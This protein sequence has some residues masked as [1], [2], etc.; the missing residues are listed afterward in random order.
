MYNEKTIQKFGCSE[1]KTKQFEIEIDGLRA[2]IRALAQENK[3]L[4][5]QLVKQS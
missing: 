1:T 4:R 5:Q 2:Q 3:L